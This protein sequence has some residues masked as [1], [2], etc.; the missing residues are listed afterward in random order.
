MTLNILKALGNGPNIN[1]GEMYDHGVIE[2]CNID[3]Q[4]QLGEVEGAVYTFD[5]NLCAIMKTVVEDDGEGNVKIMQ[6]V[7]HIIKPHN[8]IYYSE[9]V[10]DDNEATDS[11]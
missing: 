9:G 1:K 3:K 10:T 11:M 7:V 4:F 6:D 2:D 5:S 8:Y